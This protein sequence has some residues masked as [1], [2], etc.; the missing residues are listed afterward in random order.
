[1]ASRIVKNYANLNMQQI[2]RARQA[3]TD[4]EFEQYLDELEKN[5][6]TWRTR[7]SIVKEPQ[8]VG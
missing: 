8:E 3:L 4:T 6:E 1:M 2:E 7:Y 5:V